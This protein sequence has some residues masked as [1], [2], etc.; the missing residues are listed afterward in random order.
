VWCTEFALTY[1]QILDRPPRYRLTMTSQVGDG[2]R[3]PSEAANRWS[4]TDKD[5]SVRSS[6]RSMRP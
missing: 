3:M 2:R 1:E 4:T 5:L 6:E